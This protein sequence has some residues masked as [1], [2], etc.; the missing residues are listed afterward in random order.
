MKICIVTSTR[1]DFGLL[2]NLILKIK[3]NNINYKLIV[4]GAHLSKYYGS[5]IVAPTNNL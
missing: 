1:A 2:K 5:T 3:K 4:I